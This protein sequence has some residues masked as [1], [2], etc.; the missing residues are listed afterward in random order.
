MGTHTKWIPEGHA[1]ERLERPRDR[2]DVVL[3]P[4]R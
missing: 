1:Y 3:T 2:A 4:G